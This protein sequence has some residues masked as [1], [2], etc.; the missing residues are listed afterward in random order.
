MKDW[1]FRRT[2]WAI[3]NVDLPVLLSPHGMSFR[4]AIAQQPVNIAKH[5]FDIAVTFAGEHRS[6]VEPIVRE[7]EKDLEP[8]MF[9][10]TTII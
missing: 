10:M 3:K 5:H 4:P 2:H 8:T 7:V 9:S 1:E 6:V